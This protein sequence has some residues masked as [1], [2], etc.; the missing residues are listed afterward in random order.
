[1]ASWQAVIL[2]S[3]VWQINP[4]DTGDLAAQCTGLGS[5]E[6][7]EE[8]DIL[9]ACKKDAHVYGPSLS[10]QNDWNARRATIAGTAHTQEYLMLHLA[11][12]PVGLHAC[13]G[14]HGV[15]QP[16]QL[17]AQIIHRA[18]QVFEYGQITPAHRK[19]PRLFTKLLAA[20]PL[21]GIF[22]PPYLS[23]TE[24]IRHAE[25]IGAVLSIEATVQGRIQA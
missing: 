5:S 13:S 3:S 2:E 10:K 15:Q 1:M 4:T 12:F 23:P 18:Q 25:Q 20:H 8:W 19:P 11:F 21:G 16:H 17:Q 24:I 6:L 9:I 7:D 22:R 14:V